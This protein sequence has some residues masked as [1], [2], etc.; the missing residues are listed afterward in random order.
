M[1]KKLL[2]KKSKTG[3]GGQLVYDQDKKPV[4]TTTIVEL[5]AKR[6]FEDQNAKLPEHLRMTFEEVE[7][8]T[9]THTTELSE[10]RAELSRLKEEKE[11]LN[12][13][14]E[15]EALKAEIEILK[16]RK[17]RHNTSPESK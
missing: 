2:I 5:S 8:E 6:L 11:K 12:Y 15:I 13:A 16:N 3:K 10:I 7:V 4:F 1:A 17:S 9:Y 14:S